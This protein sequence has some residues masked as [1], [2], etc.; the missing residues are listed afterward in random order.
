MPVPPKTKILFVC[1]G[2]ICRSPLAEAIFLSRLRDMQLTFHF[3][4][5]SAGT[6]NYHIGSKADPR[7]I[8]N[9]RQNG[10][11]IHHRAR[12]F[13]CQDFVR[14]DYILAMDQSNVENIYTLS[15]TEDDKKKVSL[16]RKYDP[17]HPGADVPD[18]WFGGDEGFEEVFQIIER[19]VGSF[20][21]SL[22]KK[23]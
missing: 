10:I 13:V 20:L 17:I 23:M 1:L 7:T 15:K 22:R 14:F 4:A 9:A 8:K 11:E 5:D 12:Q 16:L 2:N 3:E 19:S 6:S 21:D 18:P